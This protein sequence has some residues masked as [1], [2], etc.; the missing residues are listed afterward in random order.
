MIQSKAIAETQQTIWDLNLSLNDQDIDQETRLS[1]A[2]QLQEQSCLLVWQIQ[3]VS[4]FEEFI[5]ANI[6]RIKIDED[7]LQ[8]VCQLLAGQ[9]RNPILNFVQRIVAVFIGGR[10]ILMCK[11]LLWLQN[12]ANDFNF[13]PIEMDNIIY[14][15]QNLTEVM[16]ASVEDIFEDR[17]LTRILVLT[18]L[19][20]NEHSLVLDL[21]ANGVRFEDDEE[22]LCVI[23]AYRIDG[24]SWI[25]DRLKKIFCINGKFLHTDELRALINPKPLFFIKDLD[26][27]SAQKKRAALPII[28]T[29]SQLPEVIYLSA[30]NG[31][32]DEQHAAG[33]AVAKNHKPRKSKVKPSALT[34]VE[35]PVLSPIEQLDKAISN[36]DATTYNNLIKAN[37]NLERETLPL[38][39]AKQ[40]KLE[41][42]VGKSFGA[43]KI[44]EFKSFISAISISPITCIAMLLSTTVC[45]KLKEIFAEKI[46]TLS[47][48]DFYAGN[49][50]IALDKLCEPHLKTKAGK[51]NLVEKLASSKL[52]GEH[53]PNAI[54]DNKN[55]L[56][57]L[58]SDVEHYMPVFTVVFSPYLPNIV[59]IVYSDNGA[60]RMLL[61]YKLNPDG[62]I[63][64]H[65]LFRTCKSEETLLAALR[66]I[67]DGDDMHLSTLALF[68]KDAQGRTPLSILEEK[69]EYWIIAVEW[70]FERL[71]D[72]IKHCA[73]KYYHT[74]DSCFGNMEDMFNNLQKENTITRLF[75]AK[76]YERISQVMLFRTSFRHRVFAAY[77]ASVA[78]VSKAHVNVFRKLFGVDEFAT[79][80]INNDTFLN[81]LLT[82][83]HSDPNTP[84]RCVIESA[85]FKDA[86]CKVSP[87]NTIYFLLLAQA[88]ATPN[89][90]VKYHLNLLKDK[91][92]DWDMSIN[93]VDS[94]G[95]RA[96]D[97][98]VALGNYIAVE[99]IVSQCGAKVTKKSIYI[100]SGRPDNDDPNL[101]E[102]LIDKYEEQNLFEFLI[103]NSKE[104]RSRTLQHQDL[105]EM[106]FE[107]GID[108]LYMA[109]IKAKSVARVQLLIARGCKVDKK[110]KDGKSL[111]EIIQGQCA[112]GE[113]TD[114]EA[115]SLLESLGHGKNMERQRLTI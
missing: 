78:S 23:D 102:Y 63:F 52:W 97:Y 32:N 96:I 15:C 84:A 91:L 7:A 3:M 28:I 9:A 58:V 53:N 57:L 41:V 71:L 6:G 87:V 18:A 1:L 4:Y 105:C 70:V 76:K 60:Q 86:M 37:P 77:A 98:L 79:V 74:Y 95:D 106:E 67:K 99:F 50:L 46:V 45:N 20:I 92:K 103:N 88:I 25:T 94:S 33:N 11:M 85:E 35:V 21:I 83:E 14:Y 109:A 108:L 17:E 54:L 61:D 90:D 104:Q 38:L 10:E 100:I 66:T 75:N 64:L 8:E 44:T 115:S 51:R 72:M 13:D 93:A 59:S 12:R 48:Q 5:A 101:F 62:E 113:L 114:K 36:A 56:L 22:L 19:S 55:D 110:Y 73:K 65:V 81:N 40:A 24:M 112:N 89:A 27:T 31:S 47:D 80:M 49:A 42:F 30:S 43:S 107:D 39:I 34:V 82:I 68:A 16:Q 2:V 26:R 29:D 111:S 69:D